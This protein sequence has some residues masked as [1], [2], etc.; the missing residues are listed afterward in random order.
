MRTANWIVVAG[1][2]TCMAGAAD[3][4][5]GDGLSVDA[6]DKAWPRWQARIALGVSPGVWRADSAAFNTSVSRLSG[7]SVMGDYYFWNPSSA[8]RPATS[9][10]FR[11]TSGLIV[12]SRSSAYL[13]GPVVNAGAAGL[14]VRSLGAQP[15]RS[16]LAG[17]NADVGSDASGATPY[18]GMGYTGASLKGGWGFSADIGLMALNPGSAVKLGRVLS[19]QSL[20]DTLREMRL[21]PLLQLGVSYSF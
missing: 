3:A 9:S 2:L 11:A 14:S 21:S 19:G 13:S 8:T 15:T 6:T 10:G 4:Q 1:L 16:A 17:S 20:D 5:Q 12:G 7:L 18:V